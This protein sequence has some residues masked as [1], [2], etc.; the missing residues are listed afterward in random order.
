MSIARQLFV[1][2]S[3]LP[4]SLARE[5]ALFQTYAEQEDPALKNIGTPQ[6]EVDPALGTE[7]KTAV[8]RI[9]K[10]MDPNFFTDV[11]KIELLSGGPFGQVSSEEPSVVKVNLSKIKTEVKKQLDQA[12]KQKNVKFEAGNPEHQKIFDKVL[13]LG[14][15]EVVSHETGHVEDYQ[16]RYDP[17]TGEE[18]GG[19]FPG[20]EGVAE[21]KAK[22]VGQRISND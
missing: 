17:E 5:A 11:S 3:K 8:D 14:I 15:I 12:F 9:K 22:Q 20:G 19:A 6:V 2:A 4:S 10:T 18:I 13:M 7:V 1:F 21:N 16:P